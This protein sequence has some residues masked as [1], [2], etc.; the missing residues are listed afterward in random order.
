MILGFFARLIFGPIYKNGGVTAPVS[1]LRCQL[2]RELRHEQAK[3]LTVS[4][5]L[6]Q[7]AVKLSR[8]SYRQHHCYSWVNFMLVYRVN[9][10]SLPPTSSDKLGVINPGLVNVDHPHS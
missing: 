6:C 4:V 5:H 7:R 8:S 3:H 9:L 10:S 2:G 1:I